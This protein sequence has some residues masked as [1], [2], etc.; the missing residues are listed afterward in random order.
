MLV[1]VTEEQTASTYWKASSTL[2]SQW[3]AELG[4]PSAHQAPTP[5]PAPAYPLSSNYIQPT[6]YSTP[7]L[8]CSQATENQQAQNQNHR[9][10]FP[11]RILKIQERIKAIKTTYTQLKT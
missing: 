4:L 8:R 7:P 11:K 10:V 5:P 2:Q 1:H 3:T 9:A 6:A